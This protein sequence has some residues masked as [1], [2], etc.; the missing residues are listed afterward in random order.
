MVS[1]NLKYFRDMSHSVGVVGLA[2][3]RLYCFLS[4][5]HLVLLTFSENIWIRLCHNAPI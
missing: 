1:E 5:F 3:D 4:A 2:G